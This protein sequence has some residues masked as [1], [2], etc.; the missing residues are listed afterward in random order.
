MIN[1]FLTAL[2]AVLAFIALGLL[3][4]Q[5]CNWL[6]SSKKFYVGERCWYAESESSI[7][8]V[9]IKSVIGRK[10]L[11]EYS[12]GRCIVWGYQLIKK[13]KEND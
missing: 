8:V 9:T 11:I 1:E 5:F 3:A 12:Y 7:N 10:Y 4:F 2:V 6:R 13:E